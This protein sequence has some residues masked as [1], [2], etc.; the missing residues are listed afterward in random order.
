MN[1]AIPNDKPVYVL[2]IQ[3]T[4]NDLDELNHVNNIVYLKWVLDAAQNHWLDLTDEVLRRK[5]QW[6]VLRH[7][8]D[9]HK[10]A[11]I[12]DQIKAYTWVEWHEGAKSLR[13]VKIMRGDQLIASSKTIWC[14]LDAKTLRPKRIEEDIIGLY[15]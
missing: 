4:K 6:V 12:N 9:Y 14:L 8:I 10:P 5:Y 7:E 2:E 3:V 15:S 1:P 11:L 13:Q